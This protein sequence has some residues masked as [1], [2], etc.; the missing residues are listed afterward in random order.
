MK[1]AAKRLCIK[2]AAPIQRKHRRMCDLCWTSTYEK[3]KA[4]YACGQ[5]GERLPI[6]AAWNRTSCNGCVSASEKLRRSAHAAVKRAIRCG[7]LLPP[8]ANQ[9]ADCGDPATVY[10]HRDY[11]K[12]MAVVPVCRACNVHRGPGLPLL[13]RVMLRDDVDWQYIRNSKA[14]A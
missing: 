7:A 5:C 3:P 2:C 14:A 11:E 6:A 8:E 9:C 1:D 13:P 12:P 4:S 10:D